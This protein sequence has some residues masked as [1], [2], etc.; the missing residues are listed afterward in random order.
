MALLILVTFLEVLATAYLLFVRFNKKK[1][2][3]IKKKHPVGS[4]HFELY[5][6][7]YSTKTLL[8]WSFLSSTSVVYLFSKLYLNAHP[9]DYGWVSLLNFGLFILLLVAY[10]WLQRKGKKD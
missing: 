1:L 6:V 3:T 10:F 4:P 9:Q 8:F 2:K 5:R 7:L